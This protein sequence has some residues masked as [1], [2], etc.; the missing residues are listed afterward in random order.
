M[1]A[2]GSNSAEGRQLYFELVAVAPF[3]LHG[4]ASGSDYRFARQGERIQID[5]RDWQQAFRTPQLRH[6]GG[7]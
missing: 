1:A 3:S 7:A 6:V 4:Q 2:L 5:R